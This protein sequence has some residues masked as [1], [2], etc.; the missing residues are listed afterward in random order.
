MAL[1]SALALIPGAMGY[2]GKSALITLA[3]TP[4]TLDFGLLYRVHLK[5]QVAD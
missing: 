5:L 2:F 4:G 1:A 3:S